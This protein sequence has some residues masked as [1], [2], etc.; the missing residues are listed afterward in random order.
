MNK[1]E[2]DYE[3]RKKLIEAGKKEFLEKGYNKA[4]LRKICSDAGVTTGALYFFFENKEDLFSSIVNPPVNELKKMVVEHFN[5]DR[6]F[7]SSLNSM[8]LGNLDHSDIAENLVDH[9]YR[10]Y[11]SFILLLS[12]SKEDVLS[13]TIEEFVDLM[14]KSTIAMVSGSKFYTY[15]PFMTHW[16]AHTTVDSLV[17]VI[18]HEKDVNV[19]KQRIQSIMNYLVI[20]WVNLVMVPI[21]NPKDNKNKKNK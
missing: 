21:E 13:H 4:S 15:D 17:H 20:G 11:D 10:N 5:E 19:A 12:G 1:N 6:S 7:L 3:K 14:E 18:K 9:I 2:N 16:M 8:D